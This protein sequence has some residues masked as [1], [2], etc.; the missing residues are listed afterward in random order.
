M[1]Y[2]IPFTCSYHEVS[3][4]HRHKESPN[5]KRK[6]AEKYPSADEW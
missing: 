5:K 3:Y 6:E 4:F 2:K 1:L